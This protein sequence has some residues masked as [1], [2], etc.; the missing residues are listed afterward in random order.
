MSFIAGVTGDEG[1]MP[2]IAKGAWATWDAA[3]TSALSLAVGTYGLIKQSELQGEQ[4]ALAEAQAAKDANLLNL[5][6]SQYSGVA[7]PTFTKLAALYDKYLS[8]FAPYEPT[9]LQFAFNPKKYV[10]DYGAVTARVTPCVRSEFDKAAAAVRRAGGAC[11]RQACNM[12]LML[13]VS[14]A[15]TEVDADND[16]YRFEED[17]KRWYDEF[18]WKKLTAGVK[19]V[20]GLEGRA[21]SGLNAAAHNVQRSM[22]SLTMSY[23]LAD[24][25]VQREMA[26]LANMSD[27][28]GGVSKGA[29][30]YFG[31]SM[32]D[33]RSATSLG[34]EYGHNFA[35]EH[36]M[37]IAYPGA[38]V[39]SFL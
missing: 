24:G 3:I 25:A 38:P 29:F 32:F 14:G 19:F 21:I 12:S 36:S 30:Q 37:T 2:A 18:Y 27:F 35:S 26:V 9:F 15:L 1:L 20:S 39:A 34:T 17:Q 8:S 13:A 6:Q 10:I 5:A 28:W 22:S 4:L 7:V 11:G 16:M 23:K 33:I 31:S